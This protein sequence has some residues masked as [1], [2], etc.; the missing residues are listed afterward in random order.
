M[1]TRRTK[2]AFLALFVILSVL[3]TMPPP[4][5][6][7]AAM[8]STGQAA[9]PGRAELKLQVWCRWC[10]HQLPVFMLMRGQRWV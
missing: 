4:G 1:I 8:P 9:S 7:D 2:H 3:G 10:V 5:T 6:A